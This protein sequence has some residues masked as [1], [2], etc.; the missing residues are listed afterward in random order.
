MIKK[1][2]SGLKS[3]Y[4]TI[5]LLSGI[6]SATA[7]PPFYAWW[8]LLAVLAVVF[9]LCQG[10][11]SRRQVAAIGYLYGFGFFAAGFYWVG[12]ALLVD[13]QTFGWL[14]PF[15]LAGAGAFFGLF[16]VPPFMAWYFFK[17]ESAWGR[18]LCFAAAWVLA[19]WLRSF[20]LTGFPWNLLGTIWAFQPALIQTASI[21]GTY[22]LSFLTLLWAGAFY[23]LIRYR[24]WQ[25]AVFFAV[26]PVLMIGFGVE[27]CRRYDSRPSDVTVRLVQPS[28]PQSMKWN[29][30]MLEDN[31]R[32]YLE[33]SRQTGWQEVDFVVWGETATPFDL[34]AGEY[35]RKRIADIVPPN[36]YL[37]TGLIRYGGESDS[38]RPYNSMYVLD[39]EGETVAFYDKSH[40]V[41]F[42]EYI[43]LRSYLPQWVRPVASNITDFA[44]GRKYKNIKVGHYPEFGA[45]IC[46]E[47]IFP[48]EVINREHKPSWLIVLT[49][50]GW[51]GNSAGPYQHLT[52]AQMRA[53][54]EGVTIVR[55]A[56]SGISALIYPTGEIAQSLPL[57]QKGVLDAPLPLNLKLSTPYNY[58]GKWPVVFS[59]LLILLYFIITLKTIHRRDDAKNG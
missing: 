54:E 8:L 34:D 1:F 14:Y 52:A 23:L 35:Y 11:R 46:Y 7:F 10:A 41:P 16:M 48:D 50:D 20:F 44:T 58:Y 33:M 15:A 27:R 29:R 26:L 56:N 13:A 59:M 57:H 45:L 31:F 40:L 17:S 53:V 42:G 2:I 18:V 47:V 37:V 4:K 28:I 36:G 55:S 51:Y 39:A 6:V 12:N 5:A 19:E 22:G 38:W 9:E 21:W 30:Q 3:R 25:A 49:N 24:S 32:Q 43:P